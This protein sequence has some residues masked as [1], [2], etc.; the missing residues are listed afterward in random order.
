MKK[1]IFLAVLSSLVGCGAEE[2][3]L[4]GVNLDTNVT[5]TVSDA[6]GKNL[7]NTASYSA[8]GIKIFYKLK[9]VLVEQN[10]PNLDNPKMFFIN[11]SKDKMMLGLNHD[12]GETNPE[13]TIKWNDAETDIIKASIR[14]ENEN[15]SSSTICDKVWLNNVLVW[16]LGNSTNTR[17]VNIVK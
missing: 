9:D 1:I 11:T 3:T 17:S 8:S 2:T 15:G 4:A 14:R 5:I 16:E 13:T 6:S 10:N 7:L 12:K